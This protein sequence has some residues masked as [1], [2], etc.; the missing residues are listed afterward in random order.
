MT[1]RGLSILLAVAAL[2]AWAEAGCDPQRRTP[3]PAAGDRPMALTITTTAFIDGGAIP[4]KHT[5]DGQDVSPPLVWTDVPEGAKSLAL[6]CDDPDAP[7]PQPWVHWV[8]YDLPGDLTGLA[9][10]VPAEAPPHLPGAIQGPN[11]WG[12]AGYRG[13]APPPGG[14][15]RY[16]FRLYALDTQFKAPSLDADAL[17]AKMAGHI[18]AEGE[19]LGTYER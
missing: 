17:R 4:R 19:L 11:S 15:H 14:P 18:L 5:G 7:Q 2:L 10:G 8:I 6:I 12:T 3:P 16:F 13:P 9:E 1:A